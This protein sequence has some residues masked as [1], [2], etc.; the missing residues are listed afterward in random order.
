M[1]RVA[2][3]AE[4]ATALQREPDVSSRSFS[5]FARPARRDCLAT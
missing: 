5:F 2:A 3:L 4:A 1:V